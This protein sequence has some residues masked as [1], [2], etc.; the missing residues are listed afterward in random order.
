MTRSASAI[1]PTRYTTTQ[2]INPR[3]SRQR[4]VLRERSR[5]GALRCFILLSIQAAC[6]ADPG[7]RLT[8]GANLRTYVQDRD[9]G[10]PGNDLE[11]LRFRP[12]L[13]QGEDLHP[14]YE[15]LGEQAL[16][17]FLERQG[18]DPRIERPRADLVYVVLAGAG[19]E[20]P[21]RLRVAVLPNSHLAGRELYEAILQHGPGSWGVHRANL[22]VLGPIG[23][24]S[25]DIAFAA[26]TKL[27]CWGVFTI[28]GRDDAFVIP[29]GYTEF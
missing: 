28:A 8:S 15:Q 13:C 4:H 6:S 9:G 12:E 23:G 3:S 29:G 16:I 20:R 7:L 11:S 24:A 2:P 18:M 25:D 17:A 19:T 5:R 21:V 26:R 14:Q 1:Q 22:A 10:E 27:A